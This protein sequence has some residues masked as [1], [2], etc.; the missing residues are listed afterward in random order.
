MI[1]DY[2]IFDYMIFDYMIFGLRRATGMAPTYTIF[3]KIA[4]CP[5]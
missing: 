2:M 5:A 1:F 4:I 3:F